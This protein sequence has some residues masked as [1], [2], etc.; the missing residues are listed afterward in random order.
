MVKGLDK[1]VS[2]MV[3]GCDWISAKDEE[4]KK[5]AY[6]TLDDVCSVGCNTVDTAHGYGGGESERVIGMWMEDRGN[7]EN[8]VVLSKG[9]H[10]NR[11]RR[12][13]TPYDILSDIHDSLIRLRTSYI[14]IYVLHRDNPD[15]PVGPIVDV[16]NQLNSEGKIRAFGGSNWT[17]QRIQEANEY[18][19]KKGLLPIT[20]SSPNFGLAD[21]V[22][23]PWG[24]LNVGI[25]G[26][27]QKEAQN[28]YIA[29]PD[30]KI[31]AYSSLARGFFSGR[32]KPNTTRDEAQ[33][34][35]DRA[36]LTA[37]FHPVNLEKLARAEELAA[38]KNLTVPQIAAAYATSHP[39]NIFSLQAPRG[40][41]EM[42]QNAIAIDT[43]L[44][45]E[46]LS[47]LET[48]K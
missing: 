24:E 30:V 40:I 32:I 42:K 34:I 7:R 28:W 44:T 33:T 27:S 35:L 12:R 21:Q 31:F 26:S 46:E 11:D 13:V 18:A 23:N 15:V 2:R 6:Q 29:N 9:A 3:Y 5:I 10:P 1:Q 19:Y 14:D 36:A 20:A 47:F 48:G 4:S 8:F 45:T 39:L 25:G 41:N 17:H 16:F 43:D 37:Y 22:E 38:K